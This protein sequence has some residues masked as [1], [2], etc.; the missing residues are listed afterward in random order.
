MLKGN[1]KTVFPFSSK[2]SGFAKFPST[3]SC[4]SLASTLP[5]LRR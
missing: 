1:S 5:S 2:S 3:K 4:Q